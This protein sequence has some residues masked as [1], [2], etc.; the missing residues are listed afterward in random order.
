[1]KKILLFTLIS[2][3]FIGCSSNTD[4]SG[5]PQENLFKVETYTV[6]NVGHQS[7]TVFGTFGPSFQTQVSAYGIC[8][9]LSANPTINDSHTTESNFDAT[10][11]IFSSNLSPLSQNTTY[12]VRAYGT[13][14][15]GTMYGDQIIFSTLSQL[16]TTAGSVLDVD[17]NSYSSV[18]INSK[19]WMT[20]NL[21]VSK[22]RNG[23][24][25]PQVTDIT[26]WDDA[27][28]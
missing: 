6:T 14:S 17:G 19:Q 12:Y 26:Q 9:G 2:V 22:Y 1:M 13:T 4:S 28:T 16:Y 8:Y 3:L 10:S 23:D 11:G 18:I 20:Q 7:A 25:I 21:N 24:M 15:D 5:V 27:M